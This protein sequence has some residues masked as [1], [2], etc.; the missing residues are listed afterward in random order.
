MVLAAA[1]RVDDRAQRADPELR[2]GELDR[3]CVHR[4]EGLAG[5]SVS[6]TRISLEPARAGAMAIDAVP[7]PSVSGT[8]TAP[9]GASPRQTVPPTR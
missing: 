6:V 3:R 9:G 8:S 4:F 1:E 7:A 2:L 5:G